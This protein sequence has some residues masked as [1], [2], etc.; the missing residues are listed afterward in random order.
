MRLG[1][2]ECAA[3]CAEASRALELFLIIRLLADMENWT[4]RSVTLTLLPVFS[5]CW[6]SVSCE[7]W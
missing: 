2:Q 4:P 1:A 6:L 3:A 7:L 5:V